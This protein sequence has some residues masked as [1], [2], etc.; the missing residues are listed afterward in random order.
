VSNSSA[1]THQAATPANVHPSPAYVAAFGASQVVNEGKRH[2]SD[3]EDEEDIGVTRSSRSD[4]E[5]SPAS[6]S[7]LNGFLDQLLYSIL[8]TAKSTT[9]TALRPAVAEVLRSRLAAEAIAS[10]EEEL[11]ELLA[12]G[13]EEEEEMNQKQS[14]AERKRKWDTELV[15]KRTRLRVMVYI[16]L[17]EMED[18]DEERYV[19]E[20]DLFAGSER[21]FSHSSGLVSWAAAI[22][23]T[24]ILEYMAE[25][26]L[27][28]AGH[29]A[30]ARVRRQARH[31]GAS[32]SAS[33]RITPSSDVT[34]EDYDMEKVALNSAIGRLW[35]TWRKSLRSNHPLIGPAPIP[36]KRGSTSASRFS[37]D[38]GGPENMSLR[39]DSFDESPQAEKHTW[40]GPPEV[41]Y[42][43]YILAANIP[44]PMVDGKR[45]VEEIQ[46][47][48]LAHYPDTDSEVDGDQ[49]PSR[50]LSMRR[51]SWAVSS[52]E[53]DS[54]KNRPRAASIPVSCF[55]LPDVSETADRT[56]EI[57]DSIHPEPKAKVADMILHKRKVSLDK[58]L[59]SN[60]HDRPPTS[61]SEQERE[62]HTDESENPRSLD[63]PVSDAQ[64]NTDETDE[65]DEMERPRVMPSNN[66]KSWTHI[67]EGRRTKRLSLTQSVLVRTTSSDDSSHSKEE[68]GMGQEEESGQARDHNYTS[69]GHRR[70]SRIL[71]ADVPEKRESHAV[72]IPEPPE[73]DTT[74]TSPEQFLK[75]RSLAARPTPVESTPRVLSYHES[76][77][78]SLRP[79]T[80]ATSSDM[81]DNG[82]VSPLTDKA[83]SP[84][85]QSFSTTVKEASTLKKRG[86]TP[87]PAGSIQ[88]H[89]VVAKMS[90]SKSGGQ[91]RDEPDEINL[92]SLTSAS[93][94]GPE[95]F[96]M[97]VQ[98]GDT[99]KYTLTPESVRDHSVSHVRCFRGS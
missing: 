56:P 63:S 88:K 35:R 87:E 74:T 4:T 18:E 57:A 80:C 19:M 86:L 94:R 91:I 50:V 93:I 92:T 97:F 36:I 62:K 2:F 34:V 98:G 67:S 15:W 99:V 49:T 76:P 65:D 42:P 8:L 68:G 52:R 33:G 75:R 20:D 61:R 38:K 79:S 55:R 26:V 1:F 41:E 70:R 13:D 44:L 58:S 39:Q 69:S 29:A 72:G 95:D 53:D 48:W 32:M 6:L 14:V 16:R 7:L 30:Y 5:F 23:L 59:L 3:D 24:S 85:R 9:L 46:T 51:G 60:E 47:P 12:G 27:Q 90:G 11:S 77:H 82:S 10:A 78:S 89:P 96:E 43:E 37:R 66:R 22:F 17:G 40:E 83:P 31:P 28:V 21:R 84:W 64:S 81:G 25:Q 71:L 45:D 73:Q 54:T